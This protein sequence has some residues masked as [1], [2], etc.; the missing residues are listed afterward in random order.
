VNND[1]TNPKTDLIDPHI[2]WDTFSVQLE[3]GLMRIV[4][5]VNRSWTESTYFSLCRP[6]HQR[7]SGGK[8]PWGKCPDAGYMPCI[9]FCL[10]ILTDRDRIKDC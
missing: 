3:A 6:I 10:F 9:L 7:K 8:C 5:S 4:R 2:W 1:E